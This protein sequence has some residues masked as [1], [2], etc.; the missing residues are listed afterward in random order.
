MSIFTATI[1]CNC[2]RKNIRQ[3]F[4]YNRKIP[5]N[6]YHIKM[7]RRIAEAQKCI[8]TYQPTPRA[9]VSKRTLYS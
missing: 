2:N 9:R 7:L 5:W 3:D 8:G 4:L 1:F 6:S